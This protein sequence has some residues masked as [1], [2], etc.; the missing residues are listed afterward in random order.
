MKTSDFDFELPR[1]LIAQKPVE[2]ERDQ[3]RLMVL[4]SDQSTIQHRQFFELPTFLH[5]G[6]LLVFNDSK[7]FPGRLLG[8]K[9]GSG[10]KI[11]FL[12]LRKD[13][14]GV[15]ERWEAMVGGKRIR[16]GLAVE[17]EDDL[18]GRIVEE[19]SDNT[20][21][22]QFNE[23]G[24][25]FRAVLTTQGHTP[26]PPYIDESGLN[27][28]ELRDVYQTVYAEHEGSAAAP[29]AGFHFT[30]RLLEEIQEMGVETTTV[31]LHVGM[32]TFSPVKVDDTENHKM[33][34][35]FAI[36]SPE[37]ATAVNAAKSGGRRVIAVG[38]TSVRTL[39]SFMNGTVLEAGQKWTDIF[40]APG[41]AFK[42][43]DAMITNFH[44]PKSTLLMLVSARAGTELIKTAYKEAV[45]RKYRF[46]SFGDSMFIQ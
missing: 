7:V 32:G 31:T 26:I 6:D 4:D 2:G 40:I 38:T 1:E 9:A 3:S 42:C 15:E 44:L 24:D 46:Y 22:V 39:E 20:L 45:D 12:L 5:K 11:E 41:Y 18:K 19:A 23:L 33:H 37:T 28:D 13:G 43:V 16:A 14:E 34:S 30:D 21:W 8:H 17:F 35:E 36:V 29:T 27:E 25:A 10:G